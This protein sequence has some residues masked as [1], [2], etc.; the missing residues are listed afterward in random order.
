M[1][2]TWNTVKCLFNMSVLFIVVAF[3]QILKYY[4]MV[5]FQ[6][7]Q[8]FKYVLS[9][10]HCQLVTKKKKKEAGKGGSF[11]YKCIYA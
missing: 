6:Q 1:P 10:E 7:K 2:L 4:V 8:Y 11:H 5:S 9:S 3:S